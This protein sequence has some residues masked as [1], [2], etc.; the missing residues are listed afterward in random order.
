MWIYD[1]Y[2]NH[3]KETEQGQVL[4]EKFSAEFHTFPETFE[5]CPFYGYLSFYKPL[6]FK[7]PRGL[8]KLFNWKMFFCLVAAAPDNDYQLEFSTDGILP[9]L[10]YYG[11]L[12]A[13]DFEVVKISQLHLE[14]ALLLA[15][16]CFNQLFTHL[17]KSPDGRASYNWNTE[18]IGDRYGKY[19]STANAYQNERHKRLLGKRGGKRKGFLKPLPKVM[20]K[21]LL[22]FAL[23]LKES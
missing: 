9:E 20:V 10:M 23:P 17:I 3:L 14:Q 11:K 1:E 15:F 5:E 8:T 21:D 6:S 4:M 13:D 2:L 16:E 12:G 18:P 19:L 22:P 7:K